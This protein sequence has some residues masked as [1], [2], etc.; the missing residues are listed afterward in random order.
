[1]RPMRP[2]LQP[3]CPALVERGYCD[4]HKQAQRSLRP[5]TDAR[6]YGW[7]WQQ[8]RIE[9]LAGNPLCVEC[10]KEGR[11][12]AATVVDHIEPHRGDMAK[13]WNR[14]NWQALC[15]THHNRK[16]GAGQ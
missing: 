6:G 11:T 7:K 13:F 16:T 2:C 1:M 8:A 12:E 5:K 14:S 15:E 10:N 3:S 9:F 4:A